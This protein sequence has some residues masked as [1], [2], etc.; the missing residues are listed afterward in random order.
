M[1][2]KLDPLLHNQLRLGVISLLIGT[3]DAEFKW[4]REETGSTAGNLSVQ[5][6][7]LEDA[8]YIRIRKTF[9]G[10]YPHTRCRIT[11]EG[12]DAFESYVKALQA[13]IKK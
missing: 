3:E 6:K 5:L 12:I 9:K 2:N 7:K 4:L 8:G 1:L 10:N 13:Y 11:K